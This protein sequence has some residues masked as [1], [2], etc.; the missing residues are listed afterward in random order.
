MKQT[1]LCTYIYIY[2]LIWMYYNESIIYH[3]NVPIKYILK[4]ILTPDSNQLSQSLG[5]LKAPTV[6]KI[7]LNVKIW[8]RTP[9]PPYWGINSGFRLFCSC[10]A[11]ALALRHNPSSFYFIHNFKKFLRQELTKSREWLSVKSR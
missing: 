2:V 8:T 9:L 5:D 10:Y 4:T 3:Y 6:M 7:F 1:K 11:S